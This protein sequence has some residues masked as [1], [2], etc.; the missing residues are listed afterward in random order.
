MRLRI[1]GQSTQE[2][3]D[4]FAALERRAT[5]IK[6][7]HLR[8][9]QKDLVDV[10]LPP[11]AD[12][13][14]AAA[15][16][17]LSARLLFVLVDDV[18]RPFENGPLPAGVRRV[19]ERYFVA[20]T[21]NAVA[22]VFLTFPLESVSVVRAFA[23]STHALVAFGPWGSPSAK[24]GELRTYVVES[25]PIL[26]E[27]DVVDAEVTPTSASLAAVLIQLSPQGARSLSEMTSKNVGRRL[28]IIVNNIVVAAPVIHEALPGPS[29]Q[30]SIGGGPIDA[31][32]LVELLSAG[33]LPASVQVEDPGR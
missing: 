15:K 11:D 10:V 18:A 30:I 23:D 14:L 32:T 20:P 28:A 21:R 31:P 25:N 26:T 5:G 7:A 9:S 13:D 16:L 3:E 24:V 17:T 2:I 12:F 6:G 27:S 29:V 8:R 1:I 4:T 19:E 33:P 22:E